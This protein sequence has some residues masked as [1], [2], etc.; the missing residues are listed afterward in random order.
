MVVGVFAGSRNTAGYSIQI[1]GAE[2]QGGALVVRYTETAPAPT[3]VLAQVITSPYHLV[4]V[5]KF[6]GTV[7]FEKTQ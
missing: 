5:P 4:A 3:A 7:R 2:E 6:A 1:V